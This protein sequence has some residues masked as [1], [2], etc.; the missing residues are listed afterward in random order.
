M[1]IFSYLKDQNYFIKKIKDQNDWEKKSTKFN[2]LEWRN[3]KL[4]EGEKREFLWWD[5]PIKFFL[6]T[7]ETS[8]NNIISLPFPPLKVFFFFLG[9]EQTSENDIILLPFPLPPLP[10]FISLLS[11]LFLPSMCIWLLLIC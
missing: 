2:G 6:G 1:T 10:P 8:E 7:K 3:R 11:P 9:T 5:P 4:R